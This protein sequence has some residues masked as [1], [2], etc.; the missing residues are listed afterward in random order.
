M[1]PPP[2]GDIARRV[3]YTMVCVVVRVVLARDEWLLHA[4]ERGE[5]VIVMF[6]YIFAVAIGCAREWRQVLAT[7]DRQARC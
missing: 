3:S 7:R 1:L 4:E 5:Q 6:Y 2:F